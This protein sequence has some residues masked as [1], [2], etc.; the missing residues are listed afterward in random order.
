MVFVSGIKPSS[1]KF[2]VMDED[3]NTQDDN[4]GTAVVDIDQYYERKIQDRSMELP[5]HVGKKTYGHLNVTISCQ[6]S[7]VISEEYQTEL[8]RTLQ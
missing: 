8:M 6:V 7:K 5:L 1:L 3:D 4:I 2:D